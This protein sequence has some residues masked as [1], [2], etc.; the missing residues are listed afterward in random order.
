MR[1]GMLAGNRIELLQSGVEYFP[2]LLQAIRSAQREILLET[3]IFERDATGVEVADALRAAALRGVVV[4]LLVDGFGAREFVR[5]GLADLQSDGVEGLVFRP[6]IRQLSL[7][8]HRLRRLHRKLVV[9]DGRT[10][11]VGGINIIDDMDTPGQIP[12]RFDF[13]V[14]LQGPLVAEVHEAMARLWRLVLWAGLH[15]RLTPLRWVRPGHARVGSM[16]AAFVIRDNLRHRRDIENAYLGAI[17][18]ARHEVL[19]ANAYFFPGRAFRH[20]LIEAA[21]R[22][23]KVTLL[24]QG[25]VEYWLLHHACRVLYPNLMEA[26]V[27]IV[28][29]RK[30][31]LH[32]KVAVVDTDWATVG[33]S[34]IDPFS[35]LLAREANVVVRDRGFAADLRHALHVAIADGGCELTAVHWQ[36]QSLLQRALSWLAYG[37]LRLLLGVAGYGRRAL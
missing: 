36:R 11:F 14:R 8:R 16:H 35:L 7:R 20:A 34:N 28:E 19:I 5:S 30:S 32:A 21:G 33:S 23:V 37:L 2:V 15:R 26:G 6:E 4:R 10:A 13:A 31:F 9:I 17:R 24:L 25:R 27:R 12:P 22:G 29:Y 1:Q 3:Y 18:M